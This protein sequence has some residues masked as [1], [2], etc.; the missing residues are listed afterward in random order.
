MTVSENP[1]L[2]SRALSP[3]TNKWNEDTD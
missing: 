2:T 1:S 3:N